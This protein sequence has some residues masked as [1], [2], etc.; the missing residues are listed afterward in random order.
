MLDRAA[1]FLK[2][3]G[4]TPEAAHAVASAFASE[5]ATIGGDLLGKTVQNEVAG[6][7][8]PSL[9]RM[10]NDLLAS[11]AG[12]PPEGFALRVRERGYNITDEQVAQLWADVVASLAEQPAKSNVA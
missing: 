9:M 10:R 1:K 7:L 4:V 6:L 11:I 2:G 12:E 3:F 5:A 8:R